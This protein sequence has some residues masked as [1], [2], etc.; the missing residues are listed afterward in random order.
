[1]QQDSQTYLARRA[2]GIFF[3][4]ISIAV[5]VATI[6]SEVVFVKRAPL[7]YYPIIW[8]ASFV[9]TFGI[10]FG[11]F[12]FH[13]LVPSMRNRMKNSIKWPTY[14]KAINGLCWAGPFAIIPFF[15]HSYQYLILLGIGLGNISTY[16]LSRKYSMTD[17]R[18]QMIVGLISLAAFL[19][20]LGIDTAFFVTRQ[21]IAITISRILISIA[22]GAGGIYAL[23][24]KKD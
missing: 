21:D 10:S 11:F 14:V 7:Y 2:F 4:A 5:G 3:V 16:V 6:L 15:P 12:K 22:Y 18:E 13:K 9:V 19:A 8:I 17:N 24:I 20:V 1:V 23:T